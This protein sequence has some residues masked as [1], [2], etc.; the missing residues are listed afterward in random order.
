MRIENRKVRLDGLATSDPLTVRLSD[1]WGRERIDN[2]VIAPDT[3]S[4][5]VERVRRIAAGASD[6]LRAAEILGQANGT[7]VVERMDGS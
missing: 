2:L 6:P 7:D 4:A 5:V 1:A 3:D